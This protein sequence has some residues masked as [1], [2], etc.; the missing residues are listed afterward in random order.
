M[1]MFKKATRKQAKLKMALLGPSGS[2]KTYSALSVAKHLGHR[3][4]VIDSER[5]SASLY[6]GEVADFD[7]LEL[8]SFSPRNYVEAIHAAEREGYDVIVV[9]SLTH[10]W[11]G[12]GGALEMVDKASKRSGAGN[13]FTAWRDVTPEHNALV[14]ALVGCSC[15]LIATM[16]VKTEYVLEEDARGKKVPKKVGMA[17]IQR[18]GFEYEF[19]IVADMNLEHDMIVTKSRCSAFDNAVINK[20]G[21][22]VAD[23]LLAW[24][25]SGD[26]PE[27]AKPKLAVVAQ[28]AQQPAATQ[29]PADGAL[30]PADE[31]R[32]LVEGDLDNCGT[33]EALVA[34]AGA[35]IDVKANAKAKEAAWKAF[36]AKAMLCGFEPRELVD[37]A[38]AV[39]S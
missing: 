3:I 38:K 24:L 21:K 25:A 15:H 12:K 23:G 35:L 8:E 30:S 5:G 13:S 31:I 16:R 4:A 1:S 37:A 26:V 9:D 36:Q 11:S 39:R 17:P 29:Q 28:P 10:A 22:Q 2:G 18:D 27:P 34:W 14:D 19:S 33:R 7:V 20:P 32:M 6:A